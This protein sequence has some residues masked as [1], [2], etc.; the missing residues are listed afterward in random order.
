MEVE[1][2]ILVYS[3]GSRAEYHVM[4]T[5]VVGTKLLPLVTAGEL[6]HVS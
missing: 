1:A 6:L 2:E 5:A 3:H 4:L